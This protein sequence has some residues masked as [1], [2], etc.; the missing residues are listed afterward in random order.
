MRG[1]FIQPYF[2]HSPEDKAE[3]HGRQQRLNHKPERPQHGLLVLRRDIAFRQQPDEIPVAPQLAH[4][5]FQQPAPRQ[6][7][8][9]PG[10]FDRWHQRLRFW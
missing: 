2:T 1:D 4:R 8:P 7:F 5:N 3:Y 6:N 9:I 10:L